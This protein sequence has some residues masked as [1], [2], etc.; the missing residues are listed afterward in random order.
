ERAAAAIELLEHR[1][2]DAERGEDDDVLSRESIDGARIV[3]QELHAHRPQLLVDVGVV[4]DLA[5]QQHAPIRKPLARL[6]G[7][8]DRAIDAVTEAE[9]ARKVQREPSGSIRELFGF[10]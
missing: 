8:V 3:A 7:V 6:I 9:L 4:D 10:Y 1:D 2:R 5:G